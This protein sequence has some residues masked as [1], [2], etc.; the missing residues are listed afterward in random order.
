MESGVDT[1]GRVLNFRCPLCPRRFVFY[2]RLAAHLRS[3][4]NYRPFVC[5]DCGRAF[6]QSG[7]LARHAAVHANER[8]FVCTIC[9]RAYKHYGSLV[10]HRRTHFTGNNDAKPVVRSTD[11]S[12]AVSKNR[13]R[14]SNYGM[15]KCAPTMAPPTALPLAMWASAS[16]PLVT[17]SL[18]YQAPTTQM[19]S[20]FPHCS[21]H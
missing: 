8:P 21:D 1:K 17:S 9:D 20:S 5:S 11:S 14:A 3:H 10:N 2:C 18:R 12:A 13:S 6:T 16:V 4:T 7:Y 15:S 19:L